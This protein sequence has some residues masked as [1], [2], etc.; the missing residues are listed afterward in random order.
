M[1][2]KTD[3]ALA[4]VDAGATP[5]AAAKEQGLSTSAV[6]RALKRRAE[7]ALCPCCG[8]ALKP[9]AVLKLP[10]A[11]AEPAVPLNTA[12]RTIEADIKAAGPARKQA[13]ATSL[14]ALLTIAGG[15]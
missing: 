7:R 10:A 3:A 15:R 6:Y 4:M 13:I 5:Y 12:L 14:R 2:T 1:T 11:E 8:H 9:G